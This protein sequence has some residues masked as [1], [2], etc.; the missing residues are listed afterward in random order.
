M[1]VIDLGEI[2]ISIVE[3][4]DKRFI[5]LQKPC[6]EGMECSLEVLREALLEFYRK[7]F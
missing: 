3:T 4:A 1:Q 2:S 5:W 7:N 6:G